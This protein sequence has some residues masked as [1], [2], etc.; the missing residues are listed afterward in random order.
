MGTTAVCFGEVLWD[1]LP[2]G[3]VAGGAPMNVAIRLASL[4]NRSGVISAV[5][6]DER[7]EQLLS[8]L[9]TRNVDTAF[10]QKNS[11]L[12]TGEVNVTLDADG[13]PSYNIVS[14]SA[15]DQITV[16]EQSL[17][18]LRNADAFVFGSLACR[19]STSKETLLR[20]L[21]EKPY[22]VFD[23]NLR[24]PFYSLPFVDELMQ[25]SDLI[26]L[27]DDELRVVC[28]ASGTDNIETNV[29]FLSERTGAEIIC[30]TRGKD[31]AVVYSDEVFTEHPGF[32]VPVTDTVGS[33]DSFLAGFLSSMH[34][35]NTIARSLE[36]A[37]ALGA[38]TATQKGANP[39]F[40]I[41]EIQKFIVNNSR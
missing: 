8:L 15:W 34:S 18:A 24:A 9:R 17:N 3:A 19:N 12:P 41:D 37:C 16:T 7:G 20:F 33:G 31:G 10:I 26:K 36:F 29:R 21:E 23:V 27:N 14:P 11:S 2:D 30:V 13:I 5:G 22:A 38:M 4:G 32:S 28:S 1:N 35:G 39:E 25:H 6:D 40:T